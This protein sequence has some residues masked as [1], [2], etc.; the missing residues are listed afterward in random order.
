MKR[1][2]LNEVP[3]SSTMLGTGKPSVN[4]TMSLGQWD[5]FLQVAYDAGYNL[6]ELDDNEKPVRA[7]RKDQE[8]AG[9]N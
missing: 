9:L 2:N 5:D 8:N 4:V 7:Y 6:L 1:P 3:L